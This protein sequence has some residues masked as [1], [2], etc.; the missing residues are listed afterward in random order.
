MVTND[1][2]YMKLY[3]R[4][5]RA[6]LKSKEIVKNVKNFTL[7][8]VK[9]LDVDER[10]ILLQAAD[11]DKRFIIRKIISQGKDIIITLELE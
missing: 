8:V 2:E 11:A 10:K 3:Q 4:E 6:N 7:M 5:R 1:K 9:N